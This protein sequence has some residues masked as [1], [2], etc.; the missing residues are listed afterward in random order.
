MAPQ[1][2]RPVCGRDFDDE[3]LARVQRSA[4]AEIDPPRFEPGLPQRLDDGL[5][6]PSVG[7]YPG[8]QRA[9]VARGSGAGA[10]MNGI[11]D[12]R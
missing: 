9:A 6:G 8:D 4:Q 5:H 3:L 2:A 10:V 1:R 7:A 11:G 12:T